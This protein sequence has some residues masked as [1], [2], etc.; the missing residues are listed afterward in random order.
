M[1]TSANYKGIKCEHLFWIQQLRRQC[2]EIIWWKF[3]VCG[4][5]SENHINASALSSDRLLNPPD[6]TN[7]QI[8]KLKSSKSF[9]N[10]TWCQL[11]SIQNARCESARPNGDV[12]EKKTSRICELAWYKFQ[13]QPKPQKNVF[14]HLCQNNVTVKSEGSKGNFWI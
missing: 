11:I 3:S 5:K 6:T 12:D 8:T 9:A 7:C 1:S 4:D 13:N 2:K 10:V 14:W